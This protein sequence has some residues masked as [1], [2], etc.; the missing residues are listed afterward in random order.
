MFTPDYCNQWAAEAVFIK[1]ICNQYNKSRSQIEE[2]GTFED[3]LS[4]VMRD[5]LRMLRDFPFLCFIS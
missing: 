1:R 5:S 3:I 2:K 4:S